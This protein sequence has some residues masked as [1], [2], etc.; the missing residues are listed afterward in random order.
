MRSRGGQLF[1]VKGY[2]KWTLPLVVVG[3]NSIFIY[4]VAD[5]LRGWLDRAVGVFTLHFTWLGDFACRK[6]SM[7]QASRSQNF[8]QK[9]IF[10]R[11]PGRHGTNSSRRK[12]WQSAAYPL[13]VF[14]TST[15]QSAQ[16]W[17]VGRCARPPASIT[18]NVSNLAKPL[19]LKGD[20]FHAG[21]AN[22]V[23]DWAELLLLDTAMP[24]A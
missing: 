3:A 12:S 10:V 14:A 23:S 15:R 5:V 2:R 9:P 8:A 19:A 11:K 18:R 4:S 21:A 20:T 7:R 24:L 22:Q 16:P 1:G 13:A 6:R 17:L